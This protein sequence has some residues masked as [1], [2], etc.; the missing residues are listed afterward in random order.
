MADQSQELWGCGTLKAPNA[1]HGCKA[2]VAK[3]A[4]NSCG[5]CSSMLS[6]L[7]SAYSDLV[8][9][10]MNRVHAILAI[11][12]A[13]SISSQAFA[14]G[15][16]GH[17]T[18]AL[19]ARHYIDQS[20][21]LAAKIDAILATPPANDPDIGND[22]DLLATWAD[23]YRESD[24]PGP[25]RPRYD[26]TH[27]WHFVD[28]ELDGSNDKVSAC[29]GNTLPLTAPA[30]P[31]VPNDCVVN[32]IDQFERELRDPAT[33]PAERKLALLFLL[34]FVGDV[35]QPLH[36]A[37]NRDAG[38]NTVYVVTGHANNGTNLHSYWDSNTVRRLGSTPQKVADALLTDISL[39]D[40]AAWTTGAAADPTW[41]WADE[42]YAVAQKAYS[43]LPKKRRS[44]KER[45]K[46]GSTFQTQCLVISS[47]YA[48]WATGQ[49]RQR[50][51]M[52][53]VRLAT[54]IREALQ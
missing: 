13:T 29:F 27:N 3:Y 35:H 5:D 46:D 8:G 14:W 44:C 38:G 20:P 2:A 6:W 21:A 40:I 4:E 37:D 9:D 52:A 51:Q 1:R 54:V 39:S 48:T 19:I 43:K 42:S 24:P 18:I 28:L 11:I 12:T 45:K 10:F 16:E 31:G 25:T 23:R 22:F 32:K 41:G 26:G 47:A 53:G 30:F 17:Q 49:A 36:A 33:S 15:N 34:H 7:C 50:L